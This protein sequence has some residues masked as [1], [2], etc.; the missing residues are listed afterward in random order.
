M[1]I[2][3]TVEEFNELLMLYIIDLAMK[4]KSYLKDAEEPLFSEEFDAFLLHIS[5]K[6][7]GKLKTSYYREDAK[8]KLNFNRLKKAVEVKDKVR[9]ML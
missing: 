8:T 3:M 9:L 4:N 6:A 2:N 5:G 1:N 7:M